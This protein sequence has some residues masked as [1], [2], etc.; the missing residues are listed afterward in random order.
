MIMGRIGGLIMFYGTL[1][2]WDNQGGR[3][4][5]F[6]D[7]GAIYINDDEVS[8]DETASLQEPIFKLWDAIRM[9]IE[10]RK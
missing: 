7:G 10:N 2:L 1:Y 6:I 5:V 3:I 9:V 4:K 8:F